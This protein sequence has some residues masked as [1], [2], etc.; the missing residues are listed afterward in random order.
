MTI[1]L[2]GVKG[3]MIFRAEDGREVTMTGVELSVNLNEGREKRLEEAQK[4]NLNWTTILKPFSFT[5]KFE[6]IRVVQ[7][8]VLKPD[9][10]II[11]LQ[12]RAKE[13]E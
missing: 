8:P 13:Q 3:S 9:L 4:Y 6:L 12:A 10:R 5:G 2:E 1:K 11:R 7:A